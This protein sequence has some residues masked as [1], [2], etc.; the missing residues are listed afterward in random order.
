MALLHLR[1]QQIFDNEL[2]FGGIPIMFTGDFNQP[3]PVKKLHSKRY[4]DMG[5]TSQTKQSFT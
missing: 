4:D 5:K 1:C 3:G 2:D